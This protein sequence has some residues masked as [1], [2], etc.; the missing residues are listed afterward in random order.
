MQA[1]V[2]HAPKDLRIEDA[3][4]ALPLA[5]GQLRVRV[6]RGGICGSDL[7]Y[8]QHGGFGAVRLKEP[9]VL[10]HE[11]SAVI[12]ETGSALERFTAGQRI[13]VSPSR[14][15][16]GC[17]YCHEGM[18]NHCLNMRFYGSAMPFPHIQGAFRESL[19]IEA[20]QAHLL[21]PTT[22]LAEGALAE[23]LSVGLHAIQRAG[24]VFGKRVLVTGCGPIG[25]LLIGSLQAAGASQI[26]AADLSDSALECARRMGASETHNLRDEP[27]ALARYS[28]EKGHFDVMFEASGSAQALRDGLT[29]VRPRGVIVT[30]GLG[31]DVSIP[32]NLVVGKE[33]DVRGTFRFHAEFAQAVDL[34]NR[35]LIDVTPVISH[36]LAFGE[37]V[38]AFELAGDKQQAMKVVLDF[39]VPD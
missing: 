34:L 17:K 6:A 35:K 14:P 27:Q 3:G 2:C 26:V 7:H 4:D 36:T 37:A 19:V 1:I 16:G 20:S 25:N 32:L 22:T 23:P 38:Q 39:G 15:C 10:G 21:A 9:M 8:Y 12:E 31:G 29:C 24:G 11:I 18:P 28:A 33:I 5:P 13:S 30:V